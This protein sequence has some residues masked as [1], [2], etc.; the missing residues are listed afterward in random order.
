MACAYQIS[1]WVVYDRV[2]SRSQGIL[3]REQLGYIGNLI[4]NNVEE[5]DVGVHVAESKLVLLRFKPSA[6]GEGVFL[7]VITGALVC[8]LLLDRSWIVRCLV[9]F[10]TIPEVDAIVRIH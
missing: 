5:D 4:L 6:T 8:K 10:R 1:R 3:T 7:I 9:K 2:Y